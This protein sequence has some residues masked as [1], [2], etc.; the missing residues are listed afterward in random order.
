MRRNNPPPTNEDVLRW[1]AEY[2]QAHGYPPSRREIAAHFGMGLSTVQDALA[3][4]TEEELLTVTPN[5]PRAMNITEA[6]MKLAS[7]PM[8]E[9]S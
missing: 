5:I 9:F 1:L 8:T 3:A 7:S 4:L 2:R 6:G